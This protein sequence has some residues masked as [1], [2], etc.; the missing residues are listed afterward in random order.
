V[1]SAPIT[2]AV[3]LAV[4]ALGAACSR[5]AVPRN[6]VRRLGEAD[7]AIITHYASGGDASVPLTAEEMKKLVQAIST[8]H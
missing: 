4:V 1:R 7:R 2:A 5:E 3:L 8:A 6:T